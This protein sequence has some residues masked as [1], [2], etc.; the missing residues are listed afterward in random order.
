MKR[1]NYVLLWFLNITL[2]TYTHGQSVVKPAVTDYLHIAQSVQMG[3]FV[4]EK[5]NDSYQNRIL[6]QDFAW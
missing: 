5:L 2:T 3:G 1:K 4:G 6:A